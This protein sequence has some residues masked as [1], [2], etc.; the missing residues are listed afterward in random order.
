M[1]DLLSFLPLFAVVVSAFLLERF[2]RKRYGRTVAAVVAFVWLFTGVGVLLKPGFDRAHGPP[3]QRFA[4]D[5]SRYQREC[6]EGVSESCY[7][8][9]LLYRRGLGVPPDS[10][11]ADSLSRRA[12]HLGYEHACNMPE[13]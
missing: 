6:D 12:C 1:S 2:I 13:R 3:E 10:S 4:R 5:A 8:L 9:G 7:R 11:R